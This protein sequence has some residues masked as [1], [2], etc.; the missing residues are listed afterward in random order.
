MKKKVVIVGIDG[1]EYYIF[2]QMIKKGLMPNLDAMMKKGHA[3]SLDC[4]V[5][6]P[7]QG[8]AS[9][10]TGKSPEKHGVYYWTL[11]NNLV[12]S[13]FIKDKFIW[14]TLGEHGIKSC[15]INMSYTYPPRPFNGYLISGLGSGLSAKS[16]SNYT[17]PENL[18]SEIKENVGEY[19][20]GCEY[21]DGS[22]NDHKKLI[23][24]I[25]QMTRLRTKTCLYIMDKY[26]PEFVFPVYRGADLIQHCYWNLLEPDYKIRSEVQ[27][28]KTLIENY[29]A[30]IDE[31]IA[32][33]FDKYNDSVD[34]IIS[35]HG[36]GPAKAIV[37]L[38]HYLAD[39]GFLLKIKSDSGKKKHNPLSFGRS[40]LKYVYL[41]T[42]KNLQI[43]RNLNKIRKNITG[44]DG[45]PIVKNQTRAY[46]DVLYGV[47]L[48]KELVAVP[49]QSVLKKKVVEELYKLNDP[50][51]GDSVIK[52]AFLK[53]DSYAKDIKGAPDI[54]FEPDERYHVTFDTKL[55]TNKVF[56]YMDQEEAAFFTGIHKRKGV[57]IVEGK[58]LFAPAK[59]EVKINDIYATVLNLFDVDS[60]A[61]ADGK[62]IFSS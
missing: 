24:D 59:S 40:V 17:Y 3:L 41:K 32:Q 25:I 14:E 58:N 30:E 31:S 21:K 8:W 18:I 27:P 43:F 16:A 61:E 50:L 49:D 13:E 34:F 57:C 20:L 7:G 4:Y 62:N 33:I 56:K 60:P 48:N 47:N 37:Y 12:N 44:S 55:D 39:K 15:V 10:I 53:E 22:M 52:K 51:T 29:Y 5:K 23:H 19:I 1:G 42:L 54:I 11:Y 2:E 36:F 35:D 26:S 46:S 45:L 6:G 9:M 38:N 28:L